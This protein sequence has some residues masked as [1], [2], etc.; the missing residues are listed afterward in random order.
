IT[1]GTYEIR[2]L[3]GWTPDLTPPAD[4]PLFRWPDLV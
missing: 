4:S 3:E 1:Y 2:L